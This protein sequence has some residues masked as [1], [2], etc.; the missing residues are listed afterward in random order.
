MSLKI[1]ITY[2]FSF[3]SIAA[4]LGVTS[5]FTVY[6]HYCNDTEIIVHSLIE[7]Q[8]ACN[9][10]TNDSNHEMH[11]VLSGC[12]TDCQLE[13]NSNECCSDNKQFY[14]I[15]DVFNISSPPEEEIYKHTYVVISAF[16][17]LNFEIAVFYKEPVSTY[18]LPPP[19]SGKQI[20]VLYHQLKTDPNLTA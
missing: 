10:M 11:D 4:F 18:S 3:F 7:S 8:V 15:S 20:V 13:S 2:L 1:L 5:G 12:S 19:L 17:L 9:H 14:K 6:T 16:V